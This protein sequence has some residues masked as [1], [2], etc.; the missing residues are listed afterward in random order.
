MKQSRFWVAAVAALLL[1]TGCGQGKAPQAQPPAG[2]T[3]TPGTSA[4]PSAEPVKTKETITVYYTD[5]NVMEVVKEQH[6][7]AYTDDLDK[8][9]QAI[10]L[11][12]KPQDQAHYP[13]WQDF[14]Y[15]SVTFDKGTLTID[16]DGKNVYNMGSGVEAMAI[17]ALRETLFQ[18]D[19]VEKIVFLV[20]GKTAGTLA[21][22]VSIDQPMTRQ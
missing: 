14:H 18:F 12:E 8:Y 7:I 11:L 21:G 22:H 3:E 5:S 19:E 13:L 2:Q 4:A 20:D 10:A 6:D 15:H 16:A 17:E 9:K 1:L